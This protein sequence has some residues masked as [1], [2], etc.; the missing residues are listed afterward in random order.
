MK[1]YALVAFNVAF[2][3]LSVGYPF[4]LYFGRYIDFSV[5]SVMFA[6]AFAWGIKAFLGFSAKNGF[7]ILSAIFCAIFALLFLQKIF[8][9]RSFGVELAYFYPVA[10]YILLLVAFLFSLRDEAIITK[11]AAISH[12]AKR[13]SDLPKEVQR[14]LVPYT[15]TL[16]KIWASYFGFCACVA[17]VLACFEDKFLWSVFCGGVC[18]VAL[19]LLFGI[20]WVYRYA[21]LI[22][23]QNL[24]KEAR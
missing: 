3:A 1:K 9:L 12:G 13:A 5:S 20:E 19:G 7:W 23:R 16:T 17:F 18:Y 8:A 14:Y 10:V 21:C 15:R 11:F 24:K 6:L 2:V 22:P 4:M